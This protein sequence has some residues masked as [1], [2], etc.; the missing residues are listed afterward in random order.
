MPAPDARITDAAVSDCRNDGVGCVE[1]A[2]CEAN[3]DGVY[4]CQTP[5]SQ[6]DAALTTDVG[7]DAA[8]SMDL[9]VDA[10]VQ[11]DQGID[12]MVTGPIPIDPPEAPPVSE[13]VRS[14]VVSIKTADIEYA[15]TDD[16][17]EICFGRAGCYELNVLDVDDRERGETEVY[18]FETQKPRALFDEVSLRTTDTSSNNNRWTPEC[19]EVRFNGNPSLSE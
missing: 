12:A 17:M 3:A 2:V 11:L 6:S 7:T 19:L 14:I 18:H 5:Q 4:G 15:G 10:A 9:G 13:T 8:L 16:P 1:P